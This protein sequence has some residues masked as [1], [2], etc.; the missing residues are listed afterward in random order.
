M[1]EKYFGNLQRGAEAKPF[2]VAQ[3]VIAEERRA[4]IHDRVDLE[5]VIMGWHTP[6][7]FAP[8]DA[9]LMLAGQILGGGKS[10]RLYRSLVYEKQIAQDVSAGSESLQLG[11]V[12]TIDVTARPGHTAREIETAI[13]EEL[14]K[15]R[16]A[17]VTGNELERARNT[18]ETGMISGLEKVGGLAE[19]LNLS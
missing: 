8:G 5:R 9:E 18:I 3:P 7:I 6:R 10:S 12:F 16:A 17:P 13:D 14:E 15:L 1:V 4:V 19:T 2:T 11:S